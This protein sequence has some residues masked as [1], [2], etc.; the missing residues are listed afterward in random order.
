MNP[1][2]PKAQQ[3]RG[4]GISLPGWL[5]DLV[6]AEAKLRRMSKSRVVEEILRDK[7]ATEERKS[8]LRKSEKHRKLS[9]LHKP[10][11]K[12]AIRAA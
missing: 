3:A 11:P 6:E 12:K 8:K 7:F 5:L 1:R 2:K 10:V 9:V 4:A